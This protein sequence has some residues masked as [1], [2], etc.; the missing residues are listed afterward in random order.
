[1]ALLA[2][3]PAC[4]WFSAPAQAGCAHPAGAARNGM[5]DYRIDSLRLLGIDGSGDMAGPVDFDPLDSSSPYRPCSGP[6]CKRNSAPSQAPTPIPSSIRTDDCLST[7]RLDR[8]P[9]HVSALWFLE[10]SLSRNHA[11]NT[12]ERPPRPA[13]S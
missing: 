3:V 2:F 10:P 1:L 6:N 11:A 13:A 7:T 9:Q 8:A 12:L 4:A 5:S